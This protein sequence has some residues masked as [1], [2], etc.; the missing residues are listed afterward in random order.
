[1]LHE[2]T[3]RAAF[4]RR[5]RGGIHEAIEARESLLGTEVTRSQRRIVVDSVTVSELV[6]R[7]QTVAAMSGT[8]SGDAVELEH[9]YGLHVVTF[10]THRPNQRTTLNDVIHLNS[11]DRTAAVVGAAISYA[12]AGH[13]VVIATATLPHAETIAEALHAAGSEPVLLTARNAHEEAD[14]FATAGAPGRITVATALAGRGVDIVLGAGDEQERKRAVEAGGLVVIGVGRFASSRLDRQLIGRCAR[15]GDPG[16][17]VFHLALDDD[18]IE[19]PSF[20]RDAVMST[21]QGGVNDSAS[22]PTISR[23]IAIAQSVHDD[24]MRDARRRAEEAD[25]ELREQRATFVQFRDRLLNA[26]RAGMVRVICGTDAASHA[27]AV[28][29]DDKIREAVDVSGNEDLDEVVERALRQAVLRAVDEEWSNH[30][31]ILEMTRFESGL[32]ALTQ[33]DTTVMYTQAARQHFDEFAARALLRSREML[34]A[35]SITVDGN[36]IQLRLR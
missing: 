27:L 6:N 18:N 7:Y 15:Q 34:E 25:H 11:L 29:V 22:V 8:L 19:L 5:T 35:V 30:L 21:R 31:Q 3:G 1:M 23:R 24:V 17:A 16:V 10:P 9:R 32:A 28:T 26:S 20:L 2:Q 14:V 12:S 4:G 33:L 36:N 13:P